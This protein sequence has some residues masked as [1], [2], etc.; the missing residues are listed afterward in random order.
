[1]IAAAVVIAL[2]LVSAGGAQARVAGSSNARSLATYA[3][4]TCLVH[5]LPGFVDQGEFSEAATVGD[6]IEVECNPSVYGTGAEVTITAAQLYDRCQ[7]NLAWYVPSEAAVQP[8]PQALAAGVATTTGGSVDLHLDADGNA[9]VALLAGPHC[10]V[11]ESLIT[12]DED[13]APFETFTTAFEVEP[14]VP[15]PEGVT[16][17]PSTEVEDAVTSSVAT[18][19]E[20][21]FPG[22]AEKRV[23]LAAG[24]LY[25]RCRVGPKTV[26]VRENGEVLPGRREIAGG[27][28]VALDNDGNGFAILMGSQSCAEGGS[29]IE[30]DLEESPFTTLTT[31]FTVLPPQPTAEPSLS[32]VKSQ[33]IAGGSAGYTSAPLSAYVGQTVDYQITVTNTGGVT[34]SFTGFGDPNCDPGTVAGGEGASSVPPG[35]SVTYTCSHKLT[36][37]G[38]YLNTAAVTGDTVGGHPLEQTSNTVEVTAAPP[39]A[40]AFTIEKLQELEGGGGFTTAPLSAFVGQTVDYEII[41]KNTGNVPLTFTSLS[42]THCDAGTIAGGPGSAALAPGSSATW[43]CQHVLSVEGTYVNVATVVAAPPGEPSLKQ[44]SPPVEVHAIVPA[45]AFTVEKLQRIAGGTGTYTTAQLSGDVGQTVEYEIVVKNTG[46]VALTLATFSDPR[47]DAG[48]IGG[49]PGG[50]P[51]QPGGSSTF[52]CTHLIT[53]QEDITNIATVEATPPAGGGSLPPLESHEVLVTVP[54]APPG[55]APIHTT[56]AGAPQ[57]ANGVL[58]TCAVSTPVLKG[59]KV[60]ERGRFTA[61]V[62]AAGVKQVTFYLDGH[63]LR[64]MRQSQARH[65]L[66]RLTINARMLAYGVHRLS[67]R[68]VMANSNC[69]QAASS[70]AF[71]RPRAAAAPEFTG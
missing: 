70:R 42:D 12:L 48:T 64:T 50:M 25:S 68:T 30:A 51:V 60:A 32:I 44:E 1:V 28:A 52:T 67:V 54:G 24:Q 34:E 31:E 40:P 43:T 3:S 56:P 23:R 55:P 53:A 49:G 46:N 18:I 58:G 8:P 61:T 62:A 22:Q 57:A 10:M 45:P 36:A 47:C 9:T 15:T 17:Y 13:E 5:S 11:G 66:F 27:E 35:G 69:A 4:G 59:A 7:H 37:T 41:V 65:G 63:K 16:A 33:K 19:V 21:E 71:V 29:L 26:W 6:V 39:P 2:A 14:D 38:A 20:V